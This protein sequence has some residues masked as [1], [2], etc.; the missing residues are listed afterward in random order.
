GQS[1]GSR[2]AASDPTVGSQSQLASW[3]AELRQYMQNRLES[4]IDQGNY[5]AALIDQAGLDL[6]IP[7]GEGEAGLQLAMAIIPGP[8]DNAAYIELKGSKF[9]ASFSKKGA[10]DQATRKI[11]R[12]TEFSL[13]VPGRVAGSY[14]RWV[15]VVTPEGRTI[16]LYHDTFNALGEFLHRGFKLPGPIRH[17]Y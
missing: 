17:V 6:I 1:Y 8:L 5:L 13:S 15:K 12:F 3:I 10:F 14:T 9:F 7:S 16:K 2:F 4:Q 11:G